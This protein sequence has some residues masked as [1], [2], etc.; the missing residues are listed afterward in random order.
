[1][2]PLDIVDWDYVKKNMKKTVYV[3]QNRF[4]LNVQKFFT[5]SWKVPREKLSFVFSYVFLYGIQNNR[6]F[7]LQ[8]FGNTI[9]WSYSCLNASNTFFLNRV[10]DFA[11]ATTTKAKVYRNIYT[12]KNACMHAMHSDGRHWKCMPFIHL[13]C[14]WCCIQLHIY[15]TIF[16][17]IRSIC[18]LTKFSS[19]HFTKMYFRIYAQTLH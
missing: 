13:A 16:Q 1:M 3:S 9:F 17:F 11:A 6:I 10:H 7:F 8:N 12:I 15:R 19:K 18:C 14:N 4:R 5:T 2:S